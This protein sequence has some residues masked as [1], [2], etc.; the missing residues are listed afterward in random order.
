MNPSNGTRSTRGGS[1]SFSPFRTD[2]MKR[3]AESGRRIS[4]TVAG[5]GGGPTGC[6]GSSAPPAGAP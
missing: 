2:R 5:C 6:C 3:P 4:A 1:W